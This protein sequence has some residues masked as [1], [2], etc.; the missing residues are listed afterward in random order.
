MTAPEFS[1]PHRID[2]IGTGE[3]SVTVDA[4]EAE[5]A[6]LAKRFD[7]AGIESLHARY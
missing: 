5:R 1:R 7:L 4:D 2:R 6:A 3:S